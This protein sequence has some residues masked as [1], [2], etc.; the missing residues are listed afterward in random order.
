[1]SAEDALQPRQFGPNGK[2]TTRPRDM[3]G[4]E[5]GQAKHVSHVEAVHTG[6]GRRVG[7]VSMLPA[8]K[9]TPPTIYKAYVSGNQRRKGVGT[10]MLDH[11]RSI[12]PNL[13]HSTA[14]SDDGKAWARARP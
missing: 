7:Y 5:P 14:L 3:W 8:F 4:N 6:S 1:M 10:A 11:L 12:E 13:Q 9:D 2:Y